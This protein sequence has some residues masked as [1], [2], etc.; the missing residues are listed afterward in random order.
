MRRG[1]KADCVLLLTIMAVA[2]M[3]LVDVLVDRRMV[4][5]LLLDVNTLAI[6]FFSN[7]GA[8]TIRSQFVGL[9][10]WAE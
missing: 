2:V 8:N 7:E 3:L 1:D 4:D 5:G 9:L 6:L 10:C